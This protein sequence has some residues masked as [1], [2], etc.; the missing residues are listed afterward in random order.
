MTVIDARIAADLQRPGMST[1]TPIVIV[2]KGLPARLGVEAMELLHRAIL[3][4]ADEELPGKA[5]TI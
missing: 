1:A 5:G 2:E 3:K 4:T